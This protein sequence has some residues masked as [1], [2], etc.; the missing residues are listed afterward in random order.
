MGPN[1]TITHQAD[2][3]PA[4]NNAN[5]TRT[6]QG[7]LKK[8]A[9]AGLCT[10]AAAGLGEAFLTATRSQTGHRQL[11]DGKSL[12]RKDRTPNHLCLHPTLRENDHRGPRL[13]KMAKWSSVTSGAL[14]GSAVLTSAA[15]H[16]AEQFF[17][18]ERASNAILCLSFGLFALSGLSII[19]T[20]FLGVIALRHT[21]CPN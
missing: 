21:Q 11:I 3:L 14:I 8:L 2:H 5:P 9:V 16:L 10:V 4:S 12:L 19:P 15:G 18:S 20:V 13:V 6:A 1:A 7:R 17:K